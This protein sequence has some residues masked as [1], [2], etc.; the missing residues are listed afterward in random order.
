VRKSTIPVYRTRHV[1]PVTSTGLFCVGCGRSITEPG[2]CRTGKVLDGP[3]FR[4]ILSTGVTATGE[5]FLKHQRVGFPSY[6]RGY[7]C[8]K[9]AACYTHVPFGAGGSFVPLVVVDPLHGL[10][11]PRTAREGKPNWKVLNTRI[12]R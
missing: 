6:A 3:T 2:H 11:T 12:T 7:L 10:P 8:S 9:C 4:M 1:G 5:H